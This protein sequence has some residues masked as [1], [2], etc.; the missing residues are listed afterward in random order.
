MEPRGGQRCTA[1]EGTRRI[2]SGDVAD[3]A[4][5][6]KA[7]VDRG[8]KGPVLVFDDESSEPVE[9]DLRGTPDDVR[10]RLPVP[11]SD[12][13]PTEE[14]PRP[15]GPGRPRLGVVAREVTLLPRHWE[16]LAAQPGGASVALRRLVDEARRASESTDRVRRGRE[17][18][19][20]FMSAMAGDEPG[21]EE[22][23]RALFA[24]DRA[25]FD[26]RTEA[27]PPDV[28]DHARALAA[29]TFDAAIATR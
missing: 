14:P 5:A 12:D 27:W 4:L 17:A 15:R 16:W 2:A 18:A 25:R 19:Y 29:P 26:A 11:T 23:T 28:R 22:A 6:V 24:G 13:L 7:V 20:R 1:F 3:V 9:L 8:A 21:F 10:R